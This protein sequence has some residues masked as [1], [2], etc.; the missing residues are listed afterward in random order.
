MF[1]CVTSPSWQRD[2]G[3]PF[4]G[5]W[6]WFSGLALLFLLYLV[7]SYNMYVSGAS[8]PLLTI[9]GI[10]GILGAGPG[11]EALCLLVAPVRVTSMKALLIMPGSSKSYAYT[12]AARRY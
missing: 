12:I 1:H 8:P 3:F 11:R 6:F 10:S 2:Q 7:S 4:W 9:C 5:N